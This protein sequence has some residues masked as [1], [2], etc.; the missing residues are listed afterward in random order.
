[1]TCVFMSKVQ[2]VFNRI[3]EVKLKQKKIKEMYR[4]ALI[5]SAEHERLKEEIKELRDKKKQVENNIKLDF[6]SEF[7]K[8]DRYKLELE[9]ESLLLSDAALN[10]VMKGELIEI[11]DEYNNKY[12]PLFTVKFRKM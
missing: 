2:E 8:L 10:H 11:T 9:S 1:M 3:N 7:E 6:R 4:D 12:E 5:N